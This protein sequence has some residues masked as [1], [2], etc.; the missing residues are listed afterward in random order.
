MYTL[1]LLSYIFLGFF[2]T[3]FP[4]IPEIIKSF[5]SLPSII[6]LPC[7]FGEVLIFLCRKLEYINNNFDLISRVTI[8]WILGTLIL[9]IIAIELQYFNVFWLFYPI[10]YGV[11]L[12][13]AVRSL[14]DKSERHYARW[15]GE[16]AAFI[17]I[18]ALFGLLP[19]TIASLFIPFPLFGINHDLPRMLVQPTLRAIEDNYLMLDTRVP[20]VLL[21]VLACHFFNVDPSSFAWSA[22]FLL[23]AVFG[24]GTYLLV[25]KVSGDRYIAL[26]TTLV[27]SF[28]LSAGANPLFTVFFDIPAQH[29]RSNTI[30][31]SVFPWVLLLAEKHVGEAYKNWRTLF[32]HLLL[33]FPLTLVMF[34]Y[35]VFSEVIYFGLPHYYKLVNWNPL[36]IPLFLAGGIGLSQYMIKENKVEFLLIYLIALTFFLIHA[37]ETIL[38]MLILYLY[39]LFASL[40]NHKNNNNFMRII[41]AIAVVYVTL[42]KFLPLSI[43]E[44]LNNLTK[45]FIHLEVQWDINF[46]F[47]ELLHEWNLLFM[48][49]FI[50]GSL[51]ILT[52]Q[53]KHSLRFLSI[54][55]LCLFIYFLPIPWTY[56]V[57][58]ELKLFMAYV[59]TFPFSLLAN[60][61]D[62]VRI[63]ILLSRKSKMSNL[64]KLRISRIHILIML[65]IIL[66]LLL[67]QPIYDRFSYWCEYF[68]QK[69]IQTQITLEEWDAALW[70]RKNV[71]KD[72]ILISDYFTMWVLTP[73]SNKV[74]AVEKSMDPPEQVPGLL[75]QL[76]YIKHSIFQANSSEDAFKAALKVKPIWVERL[77]VKHINGVEESRTRV[78]VISKRTSEWVRLDGYYGF[79][80]IWSRSEIDSRLLALFQD[81]RYFKLIY[82]NDFMYIYL[83]KDIERND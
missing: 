53:D 31:L 22:R 17:T 13:A 58:K 4:L 77:F 10:V 39:L 18:S 33:L 23:G 36:V 81:D 63:H 70:M 74:W 50:M 73:L 48:V 38:Y 80:W 59:I 75:L 56:R 7:I 14:L 49:L 54:A 24:V 27:A 29:F 45:L 44:V 68:P 35:L 25:F 37:E 82:K 15:R 26:L 28:I 46:K 8:E 60:Y 57:F 55:W 9:T 62:K 5:L 83:V 20:E 47:N 34:T 21:S 64:V 52:S 16:Q 42:C 79:T 12:L 76:R 69:G 19:V 67:V 71:P 78:I 51:T 3:R 1:L 66:L 11:L 43:S 72:A 6:I 61:V 40:E 2:I 32:K 30:L 41:V 65:I